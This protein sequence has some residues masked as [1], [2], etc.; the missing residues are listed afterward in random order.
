MANDLSALTPVLYSAAQTVA[1]EPTGSLQS[2]DMNF[3]D[4][5]VAIGDSVDVPVAGVSTSSDYT[6]AMT[7]SAGTDS[8]PS[9]V[10]VSITANKEVSWHLTG[11][12]QRSL[13]NGG[14]DQE[15]VRQK[16]QQGM[17]TLRNLA[18]ADANT[19]IYQ[20]ASSAIGTAG[21]TPFG[22]NIDLIAEAYKGLK[23]NGAPMA[24]MHMVL[25]TTAGLNARKL[26]II[27]QAD[28]A[29][30][31]QERRTGNFLRQFG[32]SIKESAGIQTHTK[33]TGTGY[34]VN[35]GTD[36]QIGD[37]DIVVDTGSNTILA[38][39][40]VTFAADTTNKYV[41]NTALA[42]NQFSIG[43]PGAKVIIPDDNAITVGNNYTANLAYERSAIVGVVRPPIIKDS[44]VIRT[45]PV[46]D[47][48]GM[49][50]LF[51]EIQGDGMTTWRLNLAWGFKVVQPEY[52]I[53]IM[54]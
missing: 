27:Q 2:I 54:G 19:A 8:T 35:D 40:V 47:Q 52:V 31:D 25:D 28:Q 9:D 22:T 37:T 49:T 4:K 16:L 21:T 41:V 7:T 3:D 51:C 10:S 1:A 32:F 42:A 14:T 5:G 53:N 17:R 15:W 24:D 29:G 43:K 48:F 23:D 20:G 39:D 36:V 11:E 44:G 38:G 45:I 50:Y 18:E 13:E 26:Q 34:L 30:T 12:Q 46:T 6:P 33:G